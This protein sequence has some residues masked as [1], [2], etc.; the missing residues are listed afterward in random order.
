MFC[1]YGL[2]CPLGSKRFGGEK[3]E[4]LNDEDDDDD[5]DDDELVDVEVVVEDVSESGSSS[6]RGGCFPFQGWYYRWFSDR[7]TWNR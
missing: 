2:L 4:S 5:D 1:I 7:S 6:S 3:E